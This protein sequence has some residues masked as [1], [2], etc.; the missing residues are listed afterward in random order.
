MVRSFRKIALLGIIASFVIVG[1]SLAAVGDKSDKFGLDTAADYA[2]VTSL[3]ISKK[4]DPL[5]VAAN[6]I[7]LALSFLGVAFFLLTLY[8]GFK[9]MTALG[10]GE[11]V[12]KAKELLEAAIIGL[13]IVLAAYGISV[14]VFK[15]FAGFTSTSSSTDATKIDCTDL[16][17][18]KKSCGV[19]GSASS[20]YNK[21]CVSNCVY[22]LKDLDLKG[23]CKSGSAC[24]T[25]ETLHSG[26]GLC[27]S[28][29]VCCE[30][31]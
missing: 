25:G 4:S 27:P 14:F 22:L 29:Q 26:S 16:K 30:L 1:N 5:E 24:S 28:G 12:E 13:V 17:N 18:E 10:T 3:E 15:S 9:W 21:Q 23:Q 7:A 19:S 20:C 2:Q 6:Y 8:A 11:K 31:P